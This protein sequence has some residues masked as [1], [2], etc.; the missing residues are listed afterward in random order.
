M[1]DQWY[2]TAGLVRIGSTSKMDIICTMYLSINI[3]DN[4]PNA[5]RRDEATYKSESTSNQHLFNNQGC[6]T[7]KG[8]VTHYNYKQL[9][10]RLEV[11]SHMQSTVNQQCFRRL[12]TLLTLG[13]NASANAHLQLLSNFSPNRPQRRA[14]VLLQAGCPSQFCR[15]RQAEQAARCVPSTTNL[16]MTIHLTSLTHAS[17]HGKASSLRHAT[18]LGRYVPGTFM[19][20]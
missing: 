2:H 11:Q 16:Q 9:F 19:E 10:V 5:F 1:C 17:A 20:T 15:N 13:N 6:D 7:E 14:Q 8:T 4:G 18:P 3:H 12:L